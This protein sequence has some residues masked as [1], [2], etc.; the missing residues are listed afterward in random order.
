MLRCLLLTGAGAAKPSQTHSPLTL[1]SLD[2]SSP[3][4]TDA[5]QSPANCVP[6]TLPHLSKVSLFKETH[7][8]RS[9]LR[10]GAAEALMTMTM[11]HLDH[12]HDNQRA[13]GALRRPASANGGSRSE[14]DVR[15]L[16]L[17]TARCCSCRLWGAPRVTALFR[18]WHPVPARSED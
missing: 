18:K 10:Q 3:W 14:R 4:P 16:E 17:V 2:S 1:S 15:G 9:P 7:V 8:I 11:S 5:R 13:S 6:V 12:F